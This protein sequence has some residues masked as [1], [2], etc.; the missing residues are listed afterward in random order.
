MNKEGLVREYKEITGATL[1]DSKTA[2][3]GVIEAIVSGLKKEGSVGIS[4]FGAFE[5]VEK[6][7]AVKKNP[8]TQAD[9]TVP[10]HKALKV[11]MSKTLKDSLR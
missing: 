11:K 8:A 5:L 9:V 1:K 2:I 3:D 4:G 6:A 10:A 7:E